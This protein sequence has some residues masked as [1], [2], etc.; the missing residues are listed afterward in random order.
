MSRRSIAVV[1][2]SLFI[3]TTASTASAKSREIRQDFH[4]EFEVQPG[5]RLELHHGDGDVTITPWDQDRIDIQ[6]RYH[7][8]IT[9]YGFGSDEQFDVK[10]EQKGDTVRVKEHRD[11]TV[12]FGFYSRK[13]LEYSYKIQ[14]PA[15]MVLDLTGDDGDVTLSGWRADLTVDLDD[16]DLFLSDIRTDLIQADMDDGDIDGS[17]IEARIE[18]SSD[19]G[20][21]VLRALSSRAVHANMDDGDTRLEFIDPPAGIVHIV[22]DDGD[23]EL[24][25]PPGASFRY[26]IGTDD[27]QVRLNLPEELSSETSSRIKDGKFFGTIGAGGDQVRLLTDDGDVELSIRDR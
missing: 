24:S 15:Y 3:L 21:L 2:V 14:A 22:S 20:D 16:G 27:G 11:G 19:D 1:L 13:R 7:V 23:M 6:V 5:A 17:N 26:E 8:D 10:F 12:N 9:R 4:G 18:V 25:L